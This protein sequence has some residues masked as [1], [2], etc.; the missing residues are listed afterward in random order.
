M[1]HAEG[2]KTS[3]QIMHR[4]LNV[5]LVRKENT[6]QTG[7]FIKPNFPDHTSVHK[8]LLLYENGLWSF[9]KTALRIHLATE[10]QK[11]NEDPA[12]H[13]LL[14]QRPWEFRVKQA[15]LTASVKV[16]ITW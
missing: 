13:V 11:L 3:T 2:G 9:A 14:D 10:K 4:A 7:T 8:T 6:N 15:Y 12:F 16:S 1:F 5:R